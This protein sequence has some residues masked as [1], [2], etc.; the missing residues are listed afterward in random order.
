MPARDIG[1]QT[2]SH[3]S[4]GH[5]HRRENGL[6]AQIRGVSLRT[7]KRCRPMEMFDSVGVQ[8]YKVFLAYP[9]GV[10]TGGARMKMGVNK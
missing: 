3:F 4:C 5:M 2:C 9:T 1:L 6:A 8:V 7:E 10:R